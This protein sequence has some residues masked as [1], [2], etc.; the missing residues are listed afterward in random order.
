MREPTACA[1]HLPCV[2]IFTEIQVIKK[3]R[4]NNGESSPG[5]FKST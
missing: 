3:N 1:A 2:V 5:T 4:N